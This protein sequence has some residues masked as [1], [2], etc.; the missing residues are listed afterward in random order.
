[1]FR[2]RLDFSKG[3]QGRLSNLWQTSLFSCLSKSECTDI[4]GEKVLSSQSPGYRWGFLLLGGWLHSSGTNKH[5][6]L[7]LSQRREFLQL[8]RQLIC[9]GAK[10]VKKQMSK[11][12]EA[13]GN[14]LTEIAEEFVTKV[15][16]S[17][18]YLNSN[19][20]GDC[21][22]P[23]GTLK[24]SASWRAALALT[25][26]LQALCKDRKS[27]LCFVRLCTSFK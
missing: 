18:L 26:L 20:T 22:R 3:S 10:W 8:Q 23:C 11:K 2:R 7:P 21:R 13:L 17:L 9:W 4:C 16:E 19:Q 5:K 15:S 25:A 6:A 12:G 24:G 14:S 1:M 27:L